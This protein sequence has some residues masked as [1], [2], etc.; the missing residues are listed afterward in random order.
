MIGVVLAG[1]LGTRMGRKTKT[2]YRIGTNKHLMQVHDRPMIDYPL[3]TLVSAGIKD[4]VV[5]IGP[6]HVESSYSALRYWEEE[7]D[8]RL[9]YALQKSAGGIAQALGL[10]EFIVGD[11]KCVVILGDN[12]FQDNLSD[13]V[14]EFKTRNDAKIFLKELPDEL[15][16]EIKDGK[17]KS[18]FGMAYTQE[19]KVVEIE[20]KP[21][22]P[23]SNY[24]VTGL[25]MYTPDVFGKIKKLKPSVRGELEI[26]D[27]NNMYIQEGRLGFYSLLGF[28]SDMGNPDSVYRT[29][30]F[31]RN[32]EKK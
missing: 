5:V 16:F 15:L 7:R 22:K 12:Y 18:R 25:Y 14:E 26:T 24:A 27:V 9:C 1:G 21:E 28:W 32:L 3:E 8:V 4:L 17:K 13:A 31:L 19:G 11:R 30:E 20:E 29:T 23:K 2:G 10:T 6:E